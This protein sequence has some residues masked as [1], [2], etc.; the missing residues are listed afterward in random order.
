MDEST[1]QDTIERVKKIVNFLSI[2][3]VIQKPLHKKIPLF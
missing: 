1:P 2:N 3:K